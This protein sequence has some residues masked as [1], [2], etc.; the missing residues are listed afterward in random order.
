MVSICMGSCGVLLLRESEFLTNSEFRNLSSQEYRMG[1][2][3]MRVRFGIKGKGV[4]FSGGKLA[5]VSGARLLP[6]ARVSVLC[7]M[8]FRASVWGRES[9][10]RDEIV[11]VSDWK[12]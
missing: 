11:C 10:S 9:L 2:S 12:N 4:L 6:L 5:S 7:V 1:L 3:S 8:I